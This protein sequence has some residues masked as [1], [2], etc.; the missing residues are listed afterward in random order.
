VAEQWSS[1]LPGRNIVVVLLVG[2]AK[3]DQAAGY[4]KP[5]SENLSDFF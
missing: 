5:L 1:L 2:D 3:V 4:R